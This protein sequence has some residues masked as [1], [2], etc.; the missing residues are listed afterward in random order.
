MSL[1]NESRWMKRVKYAFDIIRITRC[2]FD[3]SRAIIDREIYTILH[4]KYSNGRKVY[5]QYIHGYVTALIN[6]E[7]A[8]ILEHDVAFCF[9]VNGKLYTTSKK[10]TGKPK[11]K[12]FYDAGQGHMLRDAPHHHYWIGTDKRYT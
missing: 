9:N 6:S 4:R 10:D 7:R 11:D 12:E 8:N 5:N 1:L 2:T 3:E